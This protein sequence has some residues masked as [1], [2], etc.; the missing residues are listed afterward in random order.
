MIEMLI[1]EEL[2]CN[3]GFYNAGIILLIKRVFCYDIWKRQDCEPFK[4]YRTI[5]YSGKLSDK[6]DYI[7]ITFNVI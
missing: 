1:Q 4:L 5:N 2:N 6:F 3:Y 7:Y